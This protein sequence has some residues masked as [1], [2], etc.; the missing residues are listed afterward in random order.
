MGPTQTRF[1]AMAEQYGVQ[2][3]EATQ[4]ECARLGWEGLWCVALGGGLLGRGAR[5][6]GEAPPARSASRAEP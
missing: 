3:Y 6:L 5:F 2:L 4:C 1:L